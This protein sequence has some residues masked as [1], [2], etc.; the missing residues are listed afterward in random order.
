MYALG[1]LILLT[2]FLGGCRASSSSARQMSLSNKHLR[3]G[4]VPWPPFL[5]THEGENGKQFYSGVL[6]DFVKYMKEA[7]NLTITVVIPQDGIYGGGGEG[8][9]Y[10]KNNCTGLVGMLD[11]KEVDFALGITIIFKCT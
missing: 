7:R 11:R 3:M 5:N 8:Y 1:L 2:S 10:E 6:W 4:A 9:C